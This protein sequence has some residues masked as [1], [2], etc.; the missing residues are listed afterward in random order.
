[1]KTKENFTND[2]FL[3]Q[4]KTYNRKLSLLCFL[5]LIVLFSACRKDGNPNQ[6]VI[7]PD[8][9]Q[10]LLDESK[11]D[12]AVNISNFK[13]VSAH[14]VLTWNDAATVA[15]TRM[16]P[17]TGSGP[18]PPYVEARIYAM[19][20]VAM[21]DALNTIHPQYARYALSDPIQ[22]CASPNAAIAQAAHDVLVSLLPPQQ[23]YADSLL[24]AS[25]GLIPV[26]HAKSK[27]IDIGKAS[28]AAM[29]AKRQNDGAAAAQ[30]DLPQGTLP[31]QYRSTPPFDGPP[32]NGFMA[33]PGWGNVD[34]FSLSSGAAFRPE[35]PYAINSAAYTKDYNEIKSLGSSTSTTRT[36][37]Q[38]QIAL[39]WL[40]TAALGWNRIA[41]NQCI[42]RNMCAWETARLL[43][44]LQMAVADAIIAAVNAKYFYL[45]WRPI[46]AVR[47]GN[48]DGNP[49]TKGDPSWDVLVPPTPPVPDY[50][51]NHAVNGGAASELLEEFF[52][53]D[54]IAFSATS[55]SLPNVTRSFSSLSQAANENALSR[56]YA[57][58]HFRHAVVE[59]NKQGEQIGLYVIQH[60]L[61]PLH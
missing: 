36:A 4:S 8:Q 25:L 56:I 5:F 61:R 29:I 55:S 60:S 3:E 31:G 10:Q 26:G 54:H 40:E 48:V 17:L 59:G 42:K 37:D 45:Y 28:A 6:P 51:S 27:G 58:Y 49:D 38:T 39:F 12:F 23:V 13:K 9:P 57:G 19:V 50:P 20:F 46:T 15:V 1:M 14:M 2:R 7:Q 47:L 41:R 35:P 53:H 18:L 32:F 24:N 11:A 16:A 34:P 52:H 43:A 44:L 22:G 30:F 33:V 21:H